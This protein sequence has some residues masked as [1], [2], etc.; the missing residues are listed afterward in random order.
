MIRK[1]PLRKTKKAKRSAAKKTN[2]KLQEAI[3]LAPFHA[4]KECFQNQLKEICGGK[5]GLNGVM[6]TKNPSIDIVELQSLVPLLKKDAIRSEDRIGSKSSKTNKK[7]CR[8]SEESNYCDCV[9][10]S[11]DECIVDPFLENFTNPSNNPINSD[12]SSIVC[13]DHRLIAKPK[14]CRRKPNNKSKLASKK[15]KRSPP[16][17][18][19]TVRVS[20]KR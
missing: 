2:W 4:L 17:K 11:I 12:S 9:D 19:K 1:E 6:T 10:N 18:K 8:I 7:R 13:E 14:S 16:R 5:S 15:S 3:V 20:I